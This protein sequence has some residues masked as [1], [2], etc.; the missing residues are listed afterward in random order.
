MRLDL[1][2]YFKTVCTACESENCTIDIE[3]VFL[4]SENDKEIALKV[5]VRCYICMAL[6]E[7]VIT[8]LKK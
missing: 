4:V 8:I 3:N 1:G 2:K 7:K 5:V 6:E